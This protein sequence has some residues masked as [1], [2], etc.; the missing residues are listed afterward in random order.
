VKQAEVLPE[1]VIQQDHVA[2][3]VGGAGQTDA[4][5]LTAT[6]VHTLLA[7]TSQECGYNNSTKQNS[8]EH[9][10]TI[11]SVDLLY[12]LPEKA[13]SYSSVITYLCHV[14]SRQ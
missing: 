10:V 11:L 3:S 14:S 4:L 12:T 13:V 8:G 2:V 9:I 1:R 7:C 5:L 6:Q